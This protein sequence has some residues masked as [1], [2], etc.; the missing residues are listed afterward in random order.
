MKFKSVTEYAKQ[1]GITVQAVYKRIAVGSVEFVKV[2]KV[3]LI[4][5]KEG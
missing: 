1:E 5:T 4:K 3:Y 2:G